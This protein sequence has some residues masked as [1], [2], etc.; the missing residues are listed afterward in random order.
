[1]ARENGILR[2]QVAEY[3]RQ[4]R[5]L[6]QENLALRRELQ[7]MTSD[8][9]KKDSLERIIRQSE[10]R[11]KLYEDSISLQQIEI[12]RL[13]QDST[14]AENR[15]NKFKNNHFFITDDY[16]VPYDVPV[17]PIP[18]GGRNEGY[19]LYPDRS[20]GEFLNKLRFI[21]NTHSEV[22]IVVTINGPLSQ[23]EDIEDNIRA[24]LEGYCKNCRF[25][26]QFNSSGRSSQISFVFQK[27]RP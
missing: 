9:V 16:I 26:L 23:K 1:M 22:T 17:G 5:K 7:E 6:N 10:A 18:F 21:G 19:P 4:I 13:R 2:R 11:Y 27:D 12:N 14:E 25:N 15:F 3:Q 8:K 20:T 24:E